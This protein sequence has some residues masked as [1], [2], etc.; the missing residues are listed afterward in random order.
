MEQPRYPAL[1]V[2]YDG[3]DVHLLITLIGNTLSQ[4]VDAD[5]AAEFWRGASLAR[6]TID[7]VVAYC[8]SWVYV[9]N[10]FDKP[11]SFIA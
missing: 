1:R 4:Q 11:A 8:N 3:G 2:M 5:T 9:R 7:D 6:D 10:I